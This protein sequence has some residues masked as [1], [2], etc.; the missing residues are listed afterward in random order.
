MFNSLMVQRKTF[1][2]AK[3]L[4]IRGA[5]P[6]ASFCR[7]VKNPGARRAKNR[8]TK[9]YCLS[10]LQRVDQAERR[11]WAFFNSRTSYLAPTISS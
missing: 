7:L 2:L 1:A 4:R 5:P 11:R 10:T 3:K 6:A 9:A 8:G